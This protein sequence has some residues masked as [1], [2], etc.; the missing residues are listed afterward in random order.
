MYGIPSDLNLD[1]LIGQRINYVNV[2]ENMT[3]IVFSDKSSIAIDSK[4]YINDKKGILSQWIQQTGWDNEKYKK[5]I[6][7]YVKA[8]KIRSRE[9]LII[10]LE[11]DLRITIFDDSN[12][13]ESFHIYPEGIHI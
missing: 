6:G 3:V 8:Y 7:M 5:I 11:G 1:R 12:Q 2:M 13:Y 10:N 9:E 4:I